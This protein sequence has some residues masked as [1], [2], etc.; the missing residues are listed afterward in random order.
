M[1]YLY[2]VH[3]SYH[4]CPLSEGYIGITK[5]PEQ[6]KSAHKKRFPNS[7]FTILE[8]RITRDEIKFL[9][10]Q[11]RPHSNIGWNIAK[12]GAGSDMTIITRKKISKTLK[13]EVWSEERKRKVSEA[14]K[15][16]KKP[17]S[18]QHQEKINQSR[19]G[20]QHTKE[21]K[22]KISES[23]KASYHHD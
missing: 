5:N 17:R 15:G 20:Y 18:K 11:Y 6:R 21:T 23:V 22:I 7:N 3:K 1:Q 10:K 8:T 16:K 19:I 14:C 12:G 2:W 13:G 4:N 9:E